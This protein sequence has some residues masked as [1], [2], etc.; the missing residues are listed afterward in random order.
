MRSL[1]ALMT[2]VGL[3][4]VGQPARTAEIVALVDE[5]LAAGTALA[6]SIWRHAEMGYLEE[7]SSAALRAHLAGHGFAVEAGVAG[8]P[9]SFVASYGRGSPVIG[10]LAEFE[11][12][13]VADAW[14]ILVLSR[15]G[16]GQ[17]YLG[18][19][20]SRHGAAPNQRHWT[21]SRM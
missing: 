19:N 16:I 15:I 20:R 6:D 2:L 3:L 5:R 4:L 12:N 17:P 10:I 7:K 9:T 21:L 8:I 11:M 14:T 13:A 18:A 1:F